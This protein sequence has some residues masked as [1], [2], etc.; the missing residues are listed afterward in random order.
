[1]KKSVCLILALAVFLSVACSGKENNDYAGILEDMNVEYSLREDRLSMNAWWEPA[2]SVQDNHIL[3][4]MQSE[5]AS[6]VE[7]LEA[8]GMCKDTL[9]CEG[10]YYDDAAFCRML[11]IMLIDYRY[12][13]VYLMLS[14]PDIE[15]TRFEQ[16]IGKVME[17]LSLY[18]PQASIYFIADDAEDAERFAREENAEARTYYDYAELGEILQSCVNEKTRQVTASRPEE[19]MDEEYIRAKRENIEWSQIG[20]Q[21][22]NAPQEKPRILFIGDSISRGYGVYMNTYLDGYAV[23]YLCTSRGIDDKA[24]MRELEFILAQY[25]YDAIH[26]NIGL[27]FHGLDAEGYAAGMMDL[28]SRL[29]EAEPSAKLYFCNTTSIGKATRN[30]GYVFDDKA[31]AA[32]RERNEKMRVI[33]EE[34]EIPYFDMYSFALENDF[35]RTDTLHYNEEA[36]KKMAERISNFIKTGK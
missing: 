28:I 27:H 1:M 22:A 17:T 21:K 9:T 29:R 16:A 12:R 13:Q 5:Q 14:R 35:R 32:V 8:E 19:A 20:F 23:D 25:R 3:F 36:Y 34:E 18:A 24:L 15:Q 26:F 6:S 4:V 7:S 30:D 11:Q 10:I 33:C 31:S 2:T